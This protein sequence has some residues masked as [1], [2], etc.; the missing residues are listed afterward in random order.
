MRSWRS[1]RSARAPGAPVRSRPL[2]D[3]G[4]VRGPELIER[5]VETYA[6]TYP[7]AHGAAQGAAATREAAGASPPPRMHAA[8]EPPPTLPPAG[9]DALVEA[10]TVLERLGA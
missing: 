10:R 5:I 6:D 1:P 8:T 9:D 3:R 4:S 7:A 2:A